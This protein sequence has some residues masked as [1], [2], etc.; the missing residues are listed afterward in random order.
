MKNTDIIISS[1]RIIIF[2]NDSLLDF[3]SLFCTIIFINI[4]F[5]RNDLIIVS[6]AFTTVCGSQDIMVFQNRS[7]TTVES[8]FRLPRNLVRKFS[9][10]GI[11]TPNNS[12]MK[13]WQGTK[14]TTVF[15]VGFLKNNNMV[16]EISFEKLE[17]IQQHFL[18]IIKLP[19]FAIA[20]TTE[21]IKYNFILS[22]IKI[23]Y[24]SYEICMPSLYTYYVLTT[25]I[26]RYTYIQCNKTMSK[27]MKNSTY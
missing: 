10:L 16:E 18:K 7:P 6:N 2:M 8:M 21:M 22:S 4:M 25:Y 20:I 3:H 13:S 11:F 24:Q 26:Y 12:S 5:T 9:W 27:V 1:G 15:D 23:K 19:A 17:K 14:R